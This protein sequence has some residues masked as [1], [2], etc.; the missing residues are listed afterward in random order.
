MQQFLEYQGDVERSTGE[1]QTSNQ[2]NVQELMASLEN[3]ASEPTLE[4]ESQQI[5]GSLTGEK[6]SS[7]PAAEATP[8]AASAATAPGLPLHSGGGG[9]GASSSLSSSSPQQQ[10]Q[11]NKTNTTQKVL[12]NNATPMNTHT[13]HEDL[14]K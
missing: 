10:Q 11:G 2:Q 7:T 14:F 1:A 8:A 12:E 6:T 4:K 3:I 13:T 5:M 9:G